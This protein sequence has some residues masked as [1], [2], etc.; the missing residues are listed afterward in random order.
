MNFLEFLGISF[1]YLVATYVA[2]IWAPKTLYLNDFDGDWVIPGLGLGLALKQ[3]D[4]VLDMYVVLLNIRFGILV[5]LFSFF[6][7]VHFI[8]VFQGRAV[9]PV[10]L[11]GAPCSCG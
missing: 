2:V 8:G 3:Q 10:A 9:G 6:L 1:S 7:L 5:S 4:F 11:E